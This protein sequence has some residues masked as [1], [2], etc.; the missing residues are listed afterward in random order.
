V[1]EEREKSAGE[2]DAIVCCS[3]AVWGAF[4]RLSKRF[5]HHR[6]KTSFTSK[7]QAR[8]KESLALMWAREERHTKKA[9]K[10]HIFAPTKTFRSSPP[11]T[12][13]NKKTRCCVFIYIQ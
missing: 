5:Q 8:K 2:S 12:H 6:Q 1:S 10:K 9:T 7:S 13:D 3:P 11:Q 4:F